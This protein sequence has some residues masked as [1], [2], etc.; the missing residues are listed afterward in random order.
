MLWKLHRKPARQVGGVGGDAVGEND[1]TNGVPHALDD[2][3]S[4]PGVCPTW[5]PTL[6]GATNV[7]AGLTD[8]YCRT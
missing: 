5:K 1:E 4:S 3:M 8:G 2:T 6:D 7:I